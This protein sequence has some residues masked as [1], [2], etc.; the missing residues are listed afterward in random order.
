MLGVLGYQCLFIPGFTLIAKPIT[1]LLQKDCPFLW[2]KE[3]TE[4]L[5]E[6]IRQ[7]TMEPVLTHLDPNKPFKLE[8]DTS[9]YATGAILFQCDA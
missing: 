2:T 4:A 7:V 6:L 9:N 8:V 5:T 3:C 1:Q